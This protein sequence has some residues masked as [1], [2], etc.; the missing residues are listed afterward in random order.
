MRTRNTKDWAWI[1]LLTVLLGL[2]GSAHAAD[3]TAHF[4]G[5]W[6]ATF[7]YN[8]QTVT[9]VSVHNSNG[10]ANYVLLPSGYSPA[11]NGAFSAANGRYATNA[12]KPNNSGTYRF[13]N[14][15]AV[16]C[17]IQ[18]GHRR[19]RVLTGWFSSRG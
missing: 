5:S 15:D 7:P 4:Y 14:N 2:A 13:I 8:G 16:I 11:A 12:A 19:R 3:D 18:P 6:K 17:T 10:F 1:V 9:M